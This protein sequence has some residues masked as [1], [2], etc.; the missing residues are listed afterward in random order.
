MLKVEIKKVNVMERNKKDGSGTYNLQTAYVYT[1]D[2]DG[3]PK[4]YPEEIEIFVPRNNAGM[5]EPY[6]VGEYVIKPESFRVNYKRVEM[7]FMVLE[8]SKA[9]PNKA[10]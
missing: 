5:P 2:R 4:E 9:A 10:A 7:G 3:N 6:E 1:Y 8:K